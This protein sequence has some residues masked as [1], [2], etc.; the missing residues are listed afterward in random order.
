[1][2]ISSIVENNGIITVVPQKIK[3]DNT[4]I[5]DDTIN[6]SKINGLG[7]SL[8]SLQKAINQKQN[9]IPENTYDTFGAAEGVKTEILGGANTTIQALLTRI[10]NLEETVKKLQDNSSSTT[11]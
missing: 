5:D 6:Q 7:D 2:T 1:M 10:T 4:N 8:L 11:N 3:I 9:T